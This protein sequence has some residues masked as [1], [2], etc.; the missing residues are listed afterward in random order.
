MWSALPWH[1]AH[2]AVTLSGYTGER[3][4]F[5]ARIPCGW[6]Q[7]LQMA[8]FVSPIASRLPCTLVAYSAA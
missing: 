1:F 6:W 4:S 2:V 5:T 7:L 3:A 8:T